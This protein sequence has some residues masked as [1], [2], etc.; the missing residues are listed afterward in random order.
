MNLIEVLIAAGLFLGSSAAS[1]QIWS[2]ATAVLVADS[3]RLRRLDDLEAELQAGEARL[4][5][6]AQFFGSPTADCSDQLLRL[7]AVLENQPPAAGVVRQIVLAGGTQP[8]LVRLSAGDIERVRA[9]N[10]AAFG[11]CGTRGEDEQGGG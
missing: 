5:D 4:R 1:L 9:Y 3:D 6:P 8:V 2:R 10:P 7:V 11:G